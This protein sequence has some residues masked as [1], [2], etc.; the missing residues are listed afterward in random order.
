MVWEGITFQITPSKISNQSTDSW[1]W[2]P[3][4]S[5]IVPPS[6]SVKDRN[7]LIKNK[8]WPS[9]NGSKTSSDSIAHNFLLSHIKL[10]DLGFSQHID[11]HKRPRIHKGL[12]PFKVEQF[13]FLFLFLLSF[14]TATQ[15]NLFFFFFKFFEELRPCFHRKVSLLKGFYQGWLN[16]ISWG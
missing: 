12:H 5:G 4:V 15:S 16:T 11:F 10:E 2:K 8:Y 3:P 9:F 7:V 1:P 13:P 14:A 6:W